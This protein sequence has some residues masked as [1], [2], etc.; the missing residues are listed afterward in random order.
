MAFLVDRLADVLFIPEVEERLRS[1][2][3]TES[4]RGALQSLARS[5][6]PLQVHPLAPSHPRDVAGAF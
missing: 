5:A 4:R 1:F 3:T 6:Q 2:S